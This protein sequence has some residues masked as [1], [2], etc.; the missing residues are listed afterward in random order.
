[1]LVLCSP[2]SEWLLYLA[3]FQTHCQCLSFSLQFVSG[4]CALLCF[5]PAY[6][7]CFLLQFVSGCCCLLSFKPVN[8]DCTALQLVNGYCTF[9]SFRLADYVYPMFSRM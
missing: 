1:M 8:N 2:G 3:V 7:T 5:V 4:Y 6:D 9:L